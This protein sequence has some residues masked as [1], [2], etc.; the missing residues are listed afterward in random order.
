[1]NM[2]KMKRKHEE[3][4]KFNAEQMTEYLNM[5]AQY[6]DMTRHFQ[7]ITNQDLTG[8]EYAEICRRYAY[9]T[10]Q[11]VKLRSFVRGPKV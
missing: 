5:E 10:I 8:E 11:M 2:G 7:N 3:V 9:A 6:R 1:M 4:M